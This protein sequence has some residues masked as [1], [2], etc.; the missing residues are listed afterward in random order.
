MLCGSYSESSQQ[1]LQLIYE[2]LTGKRDRYRIRYFIV[3]LFLGDLSIAL[4]ETTYEALDNTPGLLE[5][6]LRN[7]LLVA[8]TELGKIYGQALAIDLKATAGGTVIK[9]Y[10]HALQQGLYSPAFGR[11][12]LAVLGDIY[13]ISVRN[14][15]MPLR[16]IP[17]KKFSPVFCLECTRTGF[18]FSC[19]FKTLYRRQLEVP[20]FVLLRGIC[21]NGQLT[22]RTEN[23][24]NLGLMPFIRVLGSGPDFMSFCYQEVR[25]FVFITI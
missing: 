13:C 8:F 18:F 16:E 6:P 1:C 11:I 17:A 25:K 12:D 4:H 3:A 15:K 10:A 7:E 9:G 22:A 5:Q 20:G 21:Y 19:H 23:I 24:L 2:L 14:C